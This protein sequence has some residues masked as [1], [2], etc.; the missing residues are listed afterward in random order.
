MWQIMVSLNKQNTTINHVD[1]M[2]KKQTVGQ[3]L[4]DYLYKQGIDTAFG[5][6]GDFVLP[7]FRYL[8]KS[9]IE[10]VTMTHEPSVGFAAD[11]YA[12]YKG[13]GLAVVTYCV[14]G[15]NM[16]NSIAC[17]YAE[18]S[19]VIVISGGPSEKDKN[20]DTMVHHK[21]KTFDTQR[22]IFE[23]VT[24]ANT[25]L[26]DPKTAA[27]EIIRVVSEAKRQSLPVYIE[28]PF[29]VVDMPINTPATTKKIAEPQSDK[30]ALAA[31]I[32]EIAGLINKSKQPVIIAGVELH[33]FR[34][35]DL[36]ANLVKKFN[37]PI[38]A[39]MLSKSVVGETNPLYI[40]VYSGAI[41]EPACHK[42]VDKSDCVML[43]GSFISDVLVGFDFAKLGRDKTIIISK[44][45]I[46]VGMHI[47]ENLEFKDVLQGLEKAKIKPRGAFKNPNPVV[48]HK[49][50]KKSEGASKITAESLFRI[51]STNL[52]ENDTV[53]CDTGD[54]L[55]GA[56][57]LR[58]SK[59]CRFFADA[60]YLSMGF[61]APAAIGAMKANPKSK[62]FALIGD[63]A[64]Q[65]TGLELSTAAKYGL[66][67]VVIVINNDGYGTQRHI[68]DGAF[69]N[70][71]MWN[72]T[73]I[74]DFIGYGKSVKVTTKGQLDDALKE[75]RKYKKLYFIEVVVPRD[76]C[77][78]SLR[79]MGEALG[80]LRNKD[81][82]KN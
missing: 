49:P 71:T 19:P 64:F 21:V 55:V 82:K 32:D 42:Y 54:A 20:L 58:S 27:A 40:G 81:K 59:R 38:A 56:I 29:D 41:S 61:A 47:Y 72:Y 39:T 13:L 2:P 67:P 80:R 44:E 28:V 46:Q 74:T 37:I 60:Y 70:I 26:T 11:C 73:K 15:L 36:A 34:L 18:R 17:A 48:L 66:A 24:C 53:V 57:S 23:E 9:K 50:L 45:R 4:F 65:M 16:L 3:F 10:I 8:E 6:P 77:S 30:A 5:I 68:L 35:T 12:R 14:G 43:I 25:V 63:G 69:N 33:R 76:D 75:A 1:Y 51:L 52:E 78:D 22:R 62:V 31:C 7:T 79:R